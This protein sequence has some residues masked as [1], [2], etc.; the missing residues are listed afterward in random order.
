MERL[1]KSSISKWMLGLVLEK[2][3]IM[4]YVKIWAMLLM[5]MASPVFAFDILQN[6][7][8]VS[9][10]IDL[11]DAAI[12]LQVNV[13][14]PV[15][16]V[17]GDGK[18]G[19][20]E[21]IC[22]LQYLAMVRHNTA[23]G[24]YIWNVSAKTISLN[25]INSN[26]TCNGPKTGA[27][28]VT[29]V[30]IASTTMTWPD[31]RMTWSRSSGTANNVVGTWTT[32]ESTTGNSLTVTFNADGTV[33][34]TGVI[35]QC[36]DAS[37]VTADAQHWPSGYSIQ[38]Y[39]PDPS[40]AAT[41]V[42]VAGPGITG[43]MALSYNTTRGQWDAYTAGT[44][45]SFGNTYPVGLPYTYTFT[46]TDTSTWTATSTVS[47]FQEKF[48]TIISPTG[49][50]TGTPT[51]SWTGIGDFGAEYAVQVNDSNYNQIWQ[52]GNLSGTSIVYGGPN[53]TLGATYNYFVVVEGGSTC[54]DG[55]SFASGSFTY[56]TSWAPID[57]V[58]TADAGQ[59]TIRWNAVDGATSYNLYWSTAADVTKT[60]G[61]KITRAI[62]PYS[63]TGLTNGTTY[64]YIVTAVKAAEEST[65]SAEVSATPVGGWVQTQLNGAIGRSLYITDTN[66]L[67]AT[68][69]GVYST[70]DDGMPWFSK[71]PAGKD[72]SDVIKSNQYILAATLDGV[73]R[74][75][76]AGKTW[77]LTNGSPGVS[78]GGS[79]IY[80][81][82]V[83]A[84]NSTHVFII[85]WARGIFR[86]A[87]DGGNWEQVFLGKDHPD[88]QDYAAGSTFIYT[89]GEN[90]FINGAKPLDGWTDVIWSSSNNGNSWTYTQS[91]SE[92]SLQSLYYDNG[93]LFAGG[94]MGVYLVFERKPQKPHVSRF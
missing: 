41:S 30:T 27:E 83:F 90:I 94:N 91:P 10:N 36:D 93:K 51:F 58:A 92:Y 65:A 64:H 63:H 80:G 17:T 25:W 78:A 20:E 1:L 38:F 71:G 22:V 24:T 42:T 76:D 21:A 74:S 33:S 9:Q 11:R 89:V 43:S 23:S 26:F 87:D 29:E 44:G 81:P 61:T 2:N 66:L 55:S 69:N 60:S 57:V 53:L 48:A 14:A 39:Y 16:S 72:V 67:A 15:D 7:L 82:H 50:V 35:L 52:A 84:K 47:C 6:D 45:V 86:S 49:T 77:A 56:G 5:M 18:I 68:Y 79:G 40:R 73:Y 34:V 70:A 75:S 46:I 13:S 28:M 37:E 85:A 59:V 3:V 32:L 88:Y 12:A 4:K 62:S 8:D 31:D 19:I 54:S